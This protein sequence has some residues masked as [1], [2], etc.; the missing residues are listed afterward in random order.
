MSWLSQNW[1]QVL[2]L[3]GDHLA[4]SLPAIA[5]SILVAVPL[6]RFAHRRPRL[7]GSLTSAAVLLYA[8]PAL[9]MLIVIPV[10]LGVPLRSDANMI[11]T[12]AVYGIALLVRSVVDGFRSVDHTVRESALAIGYS[13]LGM[14]WRVDLPL[15]LPVILAGVRVVTVSTISLA[16]IGALVG[17]A[18]LGSL[19][20]DG[21]QRGITS[22]VVVGIL[23]TA[24][25]ALALDGLLLLTGRILAP[26]RRARA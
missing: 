18:G 5:M 19:L 23:V 11:I 14:F 12:L 26:W 25:L 16:T 8:I 24:I 7:G 2:S 13:P 17:I 21:F 9:P 3:V 1:P 22:E 15:A 10:L 4:L 6:G 20:T